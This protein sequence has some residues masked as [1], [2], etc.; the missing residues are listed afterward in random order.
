MSFIYIIYYNFN[1]NI[2]SLRTSSLLL[3]DHILLRSLYSAYDF[4]S[5]TA[6]TVYRVSQR[7]F[8]PSL[9]LGKMFWRKSKNTSNLISMGTNCYAKIIRVTN[10][11]TI[12]LLLLNDR[13]FNQ[14]SCHKVSKLKNEL[15]LKI[16]KQIL[17]VD[18]RVG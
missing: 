14:K 10:P 1:L 6:Q 17:V 9:T 16:V 18:P 2:I 8:V 12:L 7:K 5:Y 4:T 15:K 3:N 13:L 11:Y